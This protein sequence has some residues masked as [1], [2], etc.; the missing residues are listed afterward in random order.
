MQRYP[1]ALGRGK[2]AD[3]GWGLGGWS[4]QSPGAIL[5]EGILRR[6]GRAR[7]H[8]QKEGQTDVGKR[9]T[10][11]REETDKEMG[12][13]RQR[14]PQGHSWADVSRGQGAEREQQVRQT[15]RDPRSRGAR[16][17]QRATQTQRQWGIWGDGQRGR[18]D[19]RSP[20]HGLWQP[21]R[22]GWRGRVPGRGC[23]RGPGG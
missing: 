13:S 5:G 15:Q 22:S 8:R 14:D 3:L 6:T 7:M 11:Q 19:A 2:G 21:E 18:W 4:F 9:L 1:R 16:E 23:V 12:M 17:G 10:Q 20:G